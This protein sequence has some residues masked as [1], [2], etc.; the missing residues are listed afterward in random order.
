[1]IGHVRLER[2]ISTRGKGA[3][4][5]HCVY[6]KPAPFQIPNPRFPIP[7]PSCMF[8]IGAHNEG[9]GSAGFCHVSIT[10]SNPAVKRC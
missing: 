7:F 8:L 5:A 1:M 9:R 3:A 10:F 4:Q 6:L 2:E